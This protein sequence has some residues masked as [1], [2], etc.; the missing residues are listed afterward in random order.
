MNKILTQNVEI[1]YDAHKHRRNLNTLVV[2]GSGA[3]KTRFYAKPNIMQGNTSFVVLDPKGEILRDT[4]KLLEAKGYEVR[5]LDLINMEKSMCYNPLL[6]A[7]SDN[8]V[9]R[10][11]TNLFKATTPKGSQS[12]DPLAIIMAIED[13]KD[14][15]FV[16][17]IFNKYSKNMYL[18]A[19]NILNNHMLYDNKVS[20]SYDIDINGYNALALEFESNDKAII[21]TDGVYYY[22][23]HSTVLDFNELTRVAASVE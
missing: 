1:G 23:I 20:T 18:I 13:E 15:L 16:E 12:Q 2:G 21:W 3:G 8:D 4:G 14:R 17:M 9:Q 5:V 6:Y 10:L 22:C 11:V 19:A 7:E